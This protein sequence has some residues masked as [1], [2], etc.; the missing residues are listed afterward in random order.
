MAVRAHRATRKR[1]LRRSNRLRYRGT[2]LRGRNAARH[3]LRA[4]RPS[5]SREVREPRL[6]ARIP[7]RLEGIALAAGESVYVHTEHH[8]GL[9]AL[10]RLSLAQLHRTD[11]CP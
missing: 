3:R 8:G 10:V 4:A 7:G 2:H 9:R 11:A 1:R 6:P 5:L